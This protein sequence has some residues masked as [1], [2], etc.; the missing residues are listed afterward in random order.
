MC[1]VLITRYNNTEHYVINLFPLRTTA[2]FHYD[3]ILELEI[4]KLVVCTSCHSD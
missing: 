3:L 4:Y 1:N 2:L